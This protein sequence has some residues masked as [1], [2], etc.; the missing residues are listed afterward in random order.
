MTASVNFTPARDWRAFSFLVLALAWSQVGVRA[1]PGYRP[2]PDITQTTKPDQ[3][4]GRKILESFRGLGIAGNF[5]LEFQLR[6]MPRRGDDRYLKGRLWGSL[7]ENGPV[8]RIAVATEAGE[9]RLLVQDGP[10]SGVWQRPPGAAATTDK[11]GVAALFTPLAQTDLTPFDLQRPY[12]Q[13][14]D[15]VFEGVTRIRGRP[16][17]KFLL[18]PPAEFTSN[19]PALT[20]VRVYLDTAFKAMMQSDQIGKDGVLLRSLSLEELKKIGEQWIFKSIDLRDET[21]RNKTRFTVTG[22][23]LNQDFVGD[24]F[25]PSALSTDLTSPP[26]D[27]VTKI[28][29]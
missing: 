10:E 2:Q 4:E 7:T 14:K 28:A 26:T 9:L 27:Q 5:F 3:E 6:V 20:G 23:A 22:A 13:W 29:P 19:Y 17:Y 21:T 1:Q 8:T 24:L 16:A 15:F 12:L 25:S 11:L 18:Y